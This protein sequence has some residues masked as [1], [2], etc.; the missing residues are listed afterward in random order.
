MGTSGRNVDRAS[1]KGG[2]G[3]AEVKDWSFGRKAVDPAVVAHFPRWKLNHWD[4]LTHDWD[5]GHAGA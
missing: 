2:D 3:R 1:R 4:E 5:L